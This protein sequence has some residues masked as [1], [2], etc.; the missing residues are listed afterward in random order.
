M[1]RKVRHHEKKI[2]FWPLLSTV[3]ELFVQSKVKN[4]DLCRAFA[5][6]FSSFLY[7]ATARCEIHITA[8]ACIQHGSHNPSQSGIWNLTSPPWSSPPP[9]I[10]FLFFVGDDRDLRALGEWPRYQLHHTSAPLSLGWIQ[11]NNKGHITHSQAKC[12]GLHSSH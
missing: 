10:V 9:W 7:T 2:S 6:A 8:G 12:A 11:Q 4:K 5:P 3:W 1:M